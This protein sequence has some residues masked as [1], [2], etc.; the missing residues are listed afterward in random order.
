MELTFFSD[1]LFHLAM[2]L[3]LTAPSTRR[4]APT[5]MPSLTRVPV[6]RIVPP[7]ALHKYRLMP[8][9][10]SPRVPKE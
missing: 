9:F 5:R 10:V 7:L 4:N 3:A 8:V 6:S 2:T 1:T